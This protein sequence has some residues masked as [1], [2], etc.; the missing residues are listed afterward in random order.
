MK[1]LLIMESYSSETSLVSDQLWFTSIQIS[2]H[3]TYKVCVCLFWGGQVF[4][5]I[6]SFGKRVKSFFINKNGTP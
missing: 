6:R 2:S 4:I 5:K 1:S 3:K